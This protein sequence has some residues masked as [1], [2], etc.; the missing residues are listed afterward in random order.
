M[1]FLNP[2]YF[3]LAIFIGAVILFYFF[4]KQYTEKTVSSNLLWEQV[5]NEWQASPWLKKLQQNLLFW[6][7][8]LALI[9]LMLAL[10]RPFWL[11]DSL[12]GEH[13]IIIIDPSASMSA[14]RGGKSRFE[15]AKEEMLELAGKLNGQQVTL[16]KA[17]EKNE[18][19]LS[20]E[21]DPT[22]IRRT[23][24]GLNLTY[25]HENMDKAL[26]LAGSLSS[27]K[28]TA[29]HIFSDSAVKNDLMEDLAGLYTVV[30]NIGEDARNVSLQS[31]GTAAAGDGISAIAVIENQ[32]AGNIETGFTVQ[33]ENEVL[34][35]QNLSLKANEQTTVQIKNLPEKPYYEASISINDGYSADNFAASIYTDPKPKV[36]T[37]GDV[38]P[39]AVKGF[40]TIGAELLQTDP[41]ALK[42]FEMKGV[43]VAEGSTL[44]ELPELPTI[45]FNTGKEKTILKEAISGDKDPL[46]EY[47]DFER[48]YISS[49]SAALEGEW[50]TVLKSGDIPLIQRGM[51]NGLPIIIVNFDL[52]DT[53]WPLLPGFPIFLYNSY[54]W[55][56][57]Q[58]DFLGYFSAGEERW[59]NIG[60]GN[61]GWEI[62]N[63]KDENLY[64][65]DLNKENFKAPVIPGTYQAVSGNQIY[66]FSV[67][68]D[69]R[70]KNAGIGESFTLNEKSSEKN[71]M[72]QR[73]NESLWFWL[74]LIA[75]I[76]IAIEWEVFRRGHRG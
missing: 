55:L 9:L 31:F 68:L 44:S 43:V 51:Q 5:L 24:D 47:A 69:E 14:E 76:L 8:L 28:D 17:G 3:I 56:S 72:I 60:T 11:E 71:S 29:L 30:H 48:V 12:K 26:L 40:Q 75:F 61:G 27:G 10:V 64:S 38:N 63:N 34:F 20:R 74:A 58:S 16:I 25:E 39:F 46:F 18:I 6:L 70:E 52:S 4:R 49:A 32:S 59:I 66:Y 35:E 7:Q 21:D 15:M 37:M 13:L 42:G 50:E 41:A 19:L 62:F 36:Y 2:I 1:Q 67:L 22:A 23:I 73:P 65:L 53:D 33:F 45:F 57:Q 54:H